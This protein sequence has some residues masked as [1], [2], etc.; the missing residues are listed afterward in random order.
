MRPELTITYG[1][2]TCP[3]QN[4][5]KSNQKVRGVGPSGAE[6]QIGNGRGAHLKICAGQPVSHERQPQV[7]LGGG[8]RNA[9]SQPCHGA[10]QSHPPAPRGNRRLRR[11][12]YPHG[13]WLGKKSKTLRHDARKPKGASAN[14]KSLIDCG[15]HGA[16]LL[17]PK[18]ITREKCFV[19]FAV[20]RLFETMSQ[21]RTGAQHLEELRTHFRHNHLTVSART[22][23]NTRR[24]GIRRH[25]S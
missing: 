25:A 7:L 24:P 6:D 16:E 9:G 18:I 17:A 23:E 8:R 2:K 1:V 19:G 4:Q 5:A 22:A 11:C 12:G 14:I 13:N 15:S 20:P 10:T 21:G 3:Y